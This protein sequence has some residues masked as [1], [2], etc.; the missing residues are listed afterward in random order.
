MAN[1]P[2]VYYSLTPLLGK[3]IS[4][5]KAI[6]YIP[7]SSTSTIITTSYITKYLSKSSIPSSKYLH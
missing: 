2:A 1:F 6:S 4:R 5:Q 7:T 3:S